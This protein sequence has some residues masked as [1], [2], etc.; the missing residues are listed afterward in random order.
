M[1]RLRIVALTSPLARYVLALAS[2]AAAVGLALLLAEPLAGLYFATPLGVVAL[3]ALFAGTGPGL[4]CTGA[5][6]LGL[7]VMLDP[8]ASLAIQF[9]ADGWRLLAF[10]TSGSV[11]SVVSGAQRRAHE[12]IAAE[13]G[14]ARAAAAN[15]ERAARAARDAADALRASEER[16]RTLADNIAQLVWMA[17]ADGSIFWFNKRW[18][19][20]TGTTPEEVRGRG[21]VDIP[22]PE[23]RERVV[24]KMLRCFEAGEVWEDTF[25]MRG[26]DGGYRW[27][28]SR[29]VPIKDEEGRVTRWFGSNTDVTAE[30]EHAEALREADRRKDEFIA[31]LSHELRNPL[32]PIRT[33]LDVL[34]RAPPGS[35]ASRRAMAILRRQVSQL[36]R[37]VDDLLD[38]TRISRGKLTL[39]REP[40]DLVTLVRQTVDDY[41]DLFEAGGVALA[42]SLPDEPVWIDGDAPRIA[43]AIG[44]LLQNAAK[45]TSRGGRTDVSV[46]REGDRVHVRVRDTGAGIP[47]EMLPHMFEPFTQADRTLDRSRGG[48]GLGLALVKGLVELHGGAVRAE[49]QGVGAGA[50]LTLTLPVTEP[51]APVA[52][53]PRP[54]AAPKA[55]VLVVE[56]NEDAAEMLRE[57]LCMAGHDV[58]VAHSGP[59]G[60]TRARERKPDVVLC[61]IGL[62]GM[63]GYEVA[64]ALTSVFDGARPRLVALTG[65]ASPED[66]KRAREAG[67]DAHLAKPVDLAALRRALAG[68]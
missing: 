12:R 59:D 7:W 8:R 43:Q 14:T 51:P 18:F 60:L 29:A 4:A 28:L 52:A 25:P 67:F 56:D 20:F 68:G 35:E 1:P 45:F 54:S 34:E 38:V 46:G 61:D 24:A 42:A 55:R 22:H 30:R 21:W 40:V 41:E 64:R 27:F 11:I 37:L 63:N 32:A 10:M 5:I 58:D 47:A 16:F 9:A 26:K 17:D 50:V 36:T 66:R 49:S 62:P 33:G 2:G 23:H 19:E 31:V 39:R 65:Y 44:N 48:L 53:V 13:R 3:V 57:L 6:A 15:A